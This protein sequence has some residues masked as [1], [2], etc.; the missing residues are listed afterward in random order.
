MDVE[1]DIVWVSVPFAAGVLAAQAV[2]VDLY[3]AAGA[4]LLAVAALLA[5][6]CRGR[7][8]MPA[9]VL[10]YLSLGAWCFWSG[11]LAGP[12]RIV[13][14]G[15][16]ERVRSL[17]RS[18]G[19][20]GTYTEALVEALLTGDRSGL[21]QDTV[22]AFRKS[23]ASHILALS[24]LHLG[25]I[26]LIAGKCLAVLGRSRPA[27]IARSV[28]LIGLCGLYT[29]ATGASPSIT[30]AFLFISINELARMDPSR[31]RRPL[32]IYCTALVL[33]LAFD[34]TVISSVGF[35]LSYLAM[36]GIFTVF[37]ALDSIYDGAGR[38]D[39]LKKVWSAIALSTSC[40]LLTAPLVW[41]RFH[42][43]PKYFI[44][45]NLISLP[46]TEMLVISAVLTLGLEA[47]GIH[48]AAAVRLTDLL[49][50]LLC[51]SLGIISSM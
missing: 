21:G 20:D 3:L 22:E 7:C 25:I 31:E 40:Q 42:T 33:Q 47:A 18:T 6:C 29:A 45:T 50:G 41:L 4:S 32:N 44:L 15:G 37:P 30:R 9:S 24:G 49:A 39:P 51:R 38:F 12:P 36:L 8:G 26:Y 35:Q 11:S 23:G 14:P 43:F 27:G 48:L 34:P 5:L 10:L 2:H 13:L 46:L 28:A 17:I 19:F 1:K 16:M